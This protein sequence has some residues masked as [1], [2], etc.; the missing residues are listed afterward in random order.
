MSAPVFDSDFRELNVC[1]LIPTYNNAGSLAAVLSEVLRC[2]SS[3]LVINDGST[4]DTESILRKFPQI[5]SLNSDRNQG[6]GKAL[7]KGFREAWKMGFDYVITMDSDG[8]HDAKDLE[9]FLQQWKK[10]P[11]TLIIGARNMEQENVPGKSSFGNCFSNFWFWVNTGIFLP[12]T[13]SGYR[14]YPLKKISGKR[15]FT[16]KY[17]FEIE[18]IVRASWS[19]IPVISV[20]VSVYYPSPEERVSHFRPFKDFTR[21]SILNTFLVLIALFWIKPRDFCKMLTGREGLK[22]LWQMLFHNPGESIHMKS[23]SVGFGFFMGI[24][25]VWGF[26]LALGIPLSILFR[27]NKAL[28]LIAA[29]ISIFPFTPF[30]WMASLATGKFLLGYNTWLL[31][32]QTLSLERVKQEGLAFF[33]GGTVLAFAIGGAGYILT[34]LYVFFRR[35]RNMVV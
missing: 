5:H 14:G 19:G 9:I 35:R 32:W 20:P 26:Q 30:W 25:P 6:K 34:Y 21:I 7:Q 22:K 13:Q 11:D 17:E 10:A 2:T 31:D 33:L 29:N 23:A 18:V 3:V 27:M 4:D 12:D 1:V 24:V 28:F 15:Y 16:S 8:Q